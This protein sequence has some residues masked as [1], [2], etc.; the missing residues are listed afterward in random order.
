M[1]TRA[2]VVT[3]PS[4]HGRTWTTIDRLLGDADLPAS[5]SAGARATFRRLGDIEAAQHGVSI[6]D[7]HFH[8]VGAIDA[9]LD[10]TGAWLGWH[11]LGEP[12]VSCGPI[13]IGYGTVT[14]AHGELPLPAPATAALLVGAPI[15]SMDVEGETVTPTG[16][17]ILT[18]MATRW[19]PMPS[20]TVR[21]L[22]RG[23]GGRDP[24]TYPNVVTAY[25][26]DGQASAETASDASSPPNSITESKVVVATNIDDAPGELIAFTIE[27]L[28][29]AGADDAWAN[30]IVMKKGRP[31]VELC[32]LV[33]PEA[34]TEIGH[35][36]LRE[37]GSLGFR[38]TPTAR[39]AL[40][41][42][43][44]EVHVE[45]HAIQIKV[46]P[47]GA[48]AEHDDLARASAATGRS[49]RDLAAA[50]LALVKQ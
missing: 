49:I 44:V 6:D 4:H 28:L 37:T 5:V 14:A 23:A 43:I 39:T 50:A 45:G 24:G 22:A 48:K 8:E 47:H 9:I 10:I 18:T 12:T 2:L 33:A 20:G 34:A 7:I 26:I 46:G 40:E 21:A 36:I 29:S 31:A 16:A 25:L 17:A 30:P 1:A 19:G 15:R 13:G 35:L 41:R 32:A 3:Q 42:S 27:R 38:V 11:L